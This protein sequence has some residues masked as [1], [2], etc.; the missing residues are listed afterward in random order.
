[1]RISQSAVALS[2]SYLFEQEASLQE[3]TSSKTAN[4]GILTARNRSASRIL[5]R[6][7]QV[8]VD[9]VSISGDA[10][11]E[12]RSTYSHSLSSQSCVCGAHDNETADFSQQ[13]MVEKIVSTVVKQDL[14]SLSLT[15]LGGELNSAAD[16][17]FSGQIRSAKTT[18]SWIAPQAISSRN[19]WP[20]L[21]GDRY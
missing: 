2:S 9:R 6:L 10:I 3:K 17:P 13:E 7:P 20:L 5:D 15:A 18:V 8:V 1:M 4:R 12:S 21:P 16:S 11:R 14:S 19:R